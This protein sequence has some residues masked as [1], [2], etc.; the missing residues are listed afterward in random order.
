MND[1]SL[2]IFL[3]TPLAKEVFYFLKLNKNSFN[4]L[5]KL[6]SNENINSW[7]SFLETGVFCENC[8]EFPLSISDVF[9]LKEKY[10]AEPD[11][12]YYL[13]ACVDLDKIKIQSFEDLG[14]LK[15][16]S[17]LPSRYI[18]CL[19]SK[20]INNNWLF[21]NGTTIKS[22]I[23]DV[24]Y[25]ELLLASSVIDEGY[26]LDSRLKDF[27]EYSKN[28]MPSSLQSNKNIKLLF[29]PYLL[30]AALRFKSSGVNAYMGFVK[31]TERNIVTIFKGLVDEV[32][33]SQT[34]LNMVKDIKY[35]V[36]YIDNSFSLVVNCEFEGDLSEKDLLGIVLDS[37]EAFSFSLKQKDYGDVVIDNMYT[38]SSCFS[39]KAL[40][41]L[42]E[43]I[44]VV[45]R[46]YISS[47]ILDEN[48]DIK[49]NGV[50]FKI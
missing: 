22:Q 46:K 40:P 4:L 20:Y 34:F 48:I 29:T 7:V 28:F 41:V 16:A 14:V 36:S 9:A 25:S 33:K 5:E 10:G 19:A 37:I 24:P 38:Q 31:I 12:K 50:D 30:S 45:L 3:K 17:I 23:K 43:A 15:S 42:K 2:E 18:N 44:D 32:F 27:Y 21:D 8:P 13:R 6:N 11:F 49:V 39:D 26:L 1:D 35:E 47:K